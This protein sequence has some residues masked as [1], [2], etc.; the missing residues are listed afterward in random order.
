MGETSRDLNPGL[1]GRDIRE[2]FNEQNYHLLLVAYKFQTGFDQPLLCCMYVDKKLGGIPAVRTMSRLNRAAPG[3]ERL[4]K[5]VVQLPLIFSRRRRPVS[6]YAKS[7]G[8][9]RYQAPQS[10]FAIATDNFDL[11]TNSI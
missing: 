9:G 4:E 6:K 2:A 1:K 5:T 10:L 11:D 3:K 8:V 7:S